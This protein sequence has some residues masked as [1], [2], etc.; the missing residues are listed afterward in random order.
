ME[1]LDRGTVTKEDL[2]VTRLPRWKREGFDVVADS[3]H[4]ADLGVELIDAILE[5]RGALDLSEGV[6]KFARRV[7]RDT[8]HRI[9]DRFVHTANGRRGWMVPNQYWTP[10]ALAPMAIMGKYYMHY[11]PEF[12]APR[13][14]GR[15]CAERM[16]AELVLDN[17]GVCRFH[18]G[19]AEEMLPEIVQAVFGVK[20][21]YLKSIE[22]LA[23]RINSRNASG[24][25]ESARN[26]D[27]VLAF[28][29]R[30]RDVEKDASPEL[31]RWIEAFEQDQPEA[32]LAWWYEMRKGIDEN[33]RAFL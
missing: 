3:M 24:Y 26:L 17:L 6:R 27:F 4:N 8:G 19:W 25:W 33:L 20:D 1:C 22:V 18:R 30:R 12:L 9:L 7:R 21:A 5:K 23:S 15:V 13:S 28:L 2:G 14:L 29:R 16:K 10:G 11:G 32:G 31:Q